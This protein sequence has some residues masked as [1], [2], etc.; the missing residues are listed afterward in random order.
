EGEPV[1]VR[2]L[3]IDEGEMKIGLSS[4][5]EEGQPLPAPAPLPPS[6]EKA[7]PVE[8]SAEEAV[9][10]TEASAS[11]VSVEHPE[12]AAAVEAVE[13]VEAAGEAETAEAAPKKK[14]T[15]KKA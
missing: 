15:R 1:R 11:P 4:V 8:A 12:P 6:E 7:E 14:R 13:A 2:I 9:L 3:R 10:S 5:D